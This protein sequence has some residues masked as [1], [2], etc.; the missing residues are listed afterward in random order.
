MKLNLTQP[1][2]TYC[3]NK[4]VVGNL[5]QSVKKYQ[6]YQIPVVPDR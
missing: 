3:V 6:D 1:K 2:T 4:T 5:Q